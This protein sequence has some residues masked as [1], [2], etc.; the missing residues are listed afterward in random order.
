MAGKVAAIVAMAALCAG[1][2]P[3]RADPRTDPGIVDAAAQEKRVVVYSTTD[4]ELV[5]PLLADFAE[6]YPGVAVE[7]HDLNSDELYDRFLG[8]VASGAATADVLWSSSMDLQ[9]KL[10]NDGLA[11]AYRSPEADRLPAW[12]V[13]NSEAYGTT[14]EPIAFAYNRRLLAPD[15]VP[16]S[17]AELARLLRAHPERFTG[18]VATYDPARSGIGFLLTTED[19]R[20]DPGFDDQARAYGAVGVK[21]YTTTEAMLLRVASGEHLLAFN[22]L[23]SYASARPHAE[24]GIVYPRDYTLALSRIA[25]VPKAAPHPN[26]ARV[27]LDYLLSDRGQGLIASRLR[28][29]AVRTDASGA[30]TAAA[31]ARSIGPSLV[32][33]SIGASLLVYLDAAKRREFLARWERALRAR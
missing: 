5:S 8:E 7:Y 25:L 11:A 6:L 18:K 33:I 24:V 30:A 13:W 27:L 28:L 19:D 1:P 16:R 12:A 22:V 29:G 17:H 15:E 20:I 10:A 9:M 32:P 4:A 2:P 23:S 26:A 21:L 3:A 31:L 14:F